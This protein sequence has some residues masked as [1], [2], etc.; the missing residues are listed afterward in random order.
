MRGVRT[1]S[2]GPI[3]ATAERVFAYLA[4]PDRIPEWLPGCDG[5]HLEGPIA[6][7]AVIQAR[8]GPRVAGFEIIEHGPPSPLA[9]SERKQRA[10]SVL[11]FRLDAVEGGTMVT[12]G[13]AERAPSV[14]TAI[15]GFLRSRRTPHGRVESILQRIQAARL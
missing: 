13:E 10:S 8:F 9:W 12:D 15:W 4:N 1:V 11:S 3:P 6:K 14:L 5:A 2:G 7:G